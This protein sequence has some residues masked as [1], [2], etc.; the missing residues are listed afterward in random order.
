M[1]QETFPHAGAGEHLLAP[2]PCDTR[3]VLTW[4][5]DRQPC[6]EMDAFRVLELL[7]RLRASGVS[8]WLDGGWG[9]DALLGEQTRSHD[10]LDLIVRLEDVTPLERA[11]ADLGYSR[12]HGAPPRSFEL[13][14][15]AGHQVD[16]HPVIFTASGD[17][18]YKMEEG[19]DWLYP[20]GS[21]LA[22]GTILGGAVQCQTPEMQLL[23]H[24]TGYALDTAHR[25][26]VRRLCERFGLP[27]P[28]YQPA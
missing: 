15:P 2:R 20:C 1:L 19:G 9:V 26:D 6:A 18:T 7:A 27:L 13:V 3:G 23:A 17:A 22:T 28:D 10:D 4:G 25:E 8:A 16:V 12:A 5:K 21:L 11:L 14:D 24:S